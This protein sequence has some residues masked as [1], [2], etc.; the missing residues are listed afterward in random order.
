MGNNDLKNIVKKLDILKLKVLQDDLNLREID[1]WKPIGKKLDRYLESRYLQELIDQI[2]D[3][4]TRFFLF[5]RN[6]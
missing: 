4:K 2:K 1:G 6:G 3:L 5:E